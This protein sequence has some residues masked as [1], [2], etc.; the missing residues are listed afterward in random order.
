M[1]DIDD[2]DEYDVYTYG[3]HV[4]ASVQLS[5]GDKVQTVEITGRKRGLAGVAR[6]K[7]SANPILDTR[8][9][10]VEFTDGRSEEYT[11]NIIAE[12]MYAQCDEEGN[13]LL[14]LQVIV[15]H[16]TDVHKVE[17]AD[18]FIKV[19][20]N[21]QIRYITKGWH[22]FVEWKDGKTSWKRLASLK[23][24]NPV[25]V[26]EYAATKNLI[27]EPEFA[28]WVPH[29]LKKRNRTIA[30]VTNKYHKRTHKFG[31]QVPKTWGEAVKLNKKNGNTL[32][33][34]AI[35]KDMN[36]VLIVLKVLND[37]EDIPQN[38]Q[39]IRRHMIFDEKMEYFH[40]N[41]RF[42]AG[43]HTTDAPHVMTY[44]STMSR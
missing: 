14:L 31:I 28:W 25:E 13:Q 5:I 24:S 33:Q 42:V 39:E 3:Q 29:V 18:I 8:N 7:G 1:P 27:D 17:R 41:A 12:N 2:L 40:R 44:A 43:G 4:G 23:E 11:P 15:G 37:E 16:H 10:N 22:L 20:S 26:D 19:E 35:R 30:A 6:G 21:K 38:Y 36:N 34:D 32:W 9:Y